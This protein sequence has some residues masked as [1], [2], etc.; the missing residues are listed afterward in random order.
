[1]TAINSGN[2]FRAAGTFD[3]VS[4]IERDADREL[5]K[6]I[7]KNSRYLYFLAPR[8]SGKSS[9]ISHIRKKLDE[10]I[11]KSVFIDLSTFPTN[12]LKSGN[13]FNEYFV[14]EISSVFN[15]EEELENKKDLKK[16]LEKIVKKEDKRILIFVDEIDRIL[17]SSFKDSWF[18][19]I[20]SF[21]NCRASEPDIEFGKLQFILSGA[22]TVTSLISNK[23]MSPFNVGKSIKL[24]DFT[25]EQTIEIAKHLEKGDWEVFENAAGKIYEITSGSVYLTQLILEKLWEYAIDRKAKNITKE[26]VENTVNDLITESPNNIHF[27]TIYESIVNDPETNKI[28]LMVIEDHSLYSFDVEKRKRLKITGILNENNDYRNLIYKKVFGEDGAL[29]LFRD[30]IKYK[31]YLLNMYSHLSEKSFGNILKTP[32]EIAKIYYNVPICIEGSNKEHLKEGT[33]KDQVPIPDIKGVFQTAKSRHIKDIVILGDPGTGKT[34]LLKYI[35][36]MLLNGKGEEKLGLNN[37]IIPFYVPISELS[38]PENESFIDFIGRICSFEKYSIPAKWFRTLLENEKGIILLDG[39]D[40]IADEQTRI[41]IC[42]WIDRARKKFFSTCFIVTS[43]P[44]E[45]RDK[46]RLEDNVLVL[47]IQD[48]YYEEIE[49][50]LIPLFEAV[51]TAIHLGDNEDKWKRQGRKDA[52]E[53]AGKIKESEYFNKLALNPMILQFL[54]LI[55]RNRENKLPQHRIKLYHECTEGLLNRWIMDNGSDIKLYSG[56]VRQILQSLALLFHKNG[57]PTAYIDDIEND[58]KKSLEN[59]GKSNI[60]PASLLLNIRNKSGIFKS[61]SEYEYGFT[62]LI[63]QEFFAAEKIKNDRSVDILVENYDNKWWKQVILLTLAFDNPSLL[64]E[65]IERLPKTEHFKSGKANIDLVVEVINEAPVKPIKSLVSALKNKDL[66][67]ESRRNVVQVFKKISENKISENKVIIESLQR[68]AGNP[69]DVLADSAYEVLKVL[70]AAENI[71]APSENRIITYEKDQSEMVLIPAGSFLFGEEENETREKS[72][73][74]IN[75]PDYYIDLYPITN[76]QFCLFLNETNPSDTDLNKWIYLEGKS[77][78]E[79]CRI[80]KAENNFKIEK[81]YKEHPV[82]YVTWYGAAA[83]AQWAGKRLPSEQEWE[84]AARGTDGLLF[85]WGNTFE[86][87]YCNSFE[88]GVLRTTD[89]KQFPKGKS[90]YGCYDMAGNV[91]EWTDSLFDNVGDKYVLRGGSWFSDN[92]NCRCAFRNESKPNFIRAFIGFRCAKDF[93]GEGIV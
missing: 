10:T 93:K 76:R 69:H 78:S 83:Y 14:N 51:E 13:S 85:P 16:V 67:P 19:L 15:F 74:I 44:V 62:F 22:A 77:E 1:M 29:S 37:D 54:A 5:Y 46:S 18:G 27:N 39:L 35:M 52:I 11:F 2:P 57:K 33:R 30:D 56:E 36:I 20:R 6:E 63:F 49:S 84:K 82:I 60:D 8:Q 89:V 42:N 47:S 32:V 68:I 26:D 50:L 12:C 58:I 45:Y 34:I 3:G 75:L 23:I 91:F 79:K 65:F 9:L 70:D 24:H 31:K 86:K 61:Y 21:F 72:K 41:K 43:R 87:Q 64:E 48:F 81:G 38:D 53:I 80:I 55:L 73:Q 90:P 88:S 71:K 17:H 25:Y 66:P 59:S 4:Y 40:Q 92:Y 7:I 28:F